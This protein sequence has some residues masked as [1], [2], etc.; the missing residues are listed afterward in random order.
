MSLRDDEFRM[1][2]SAAM[3]DHAMADVELYELP[4]ARMKPLVAWALLPHGFA[5]EAFRRA[6]TDAPEP[7]MSRGKAVR[8]HARNLAILKRKVATIALITHEEPHAH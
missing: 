8:A 3:L 1:G 2:Y 5:K 6:V 7:R 4:E